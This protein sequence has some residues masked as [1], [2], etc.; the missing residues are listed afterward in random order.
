M[1]CVLVLFYAK[2][3]AILIG[4][5]RSSAASWVEKESGT[6]SKLNQNFAHKSAESF[7]ACSLNY[8]SLLFTG[9]RFLCW[10]LGPLGTSLIWGAR[11]VA[12]A[13]C[14]ET[15]LGKLVSPG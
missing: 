8:S 11:P 5:S 13:C 7:V 1:W 15:D 6:C 10:A 4:L 14:A 9:S 3:K 12:Q 2:K